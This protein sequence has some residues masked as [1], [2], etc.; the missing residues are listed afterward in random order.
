[1]AATERT[2]TSARRTTA[3]AEDKDTAATSSERGTEQTDTEQADTEQHDKDHPR[4]AT[5]NLPFVTA[6]FRAPDLHLPKPKPQEIGAALQ[7]ARSFLPPPRQALYYGGLALMAALEVVEWPVAAAIGVG[8][9][10]AGRGGGGDRGG[11]GAASK[12][13]E[14]ESSQEKNATESS[15]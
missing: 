9:A 4:T 5:V 1:M 2:R 11:G 14:T 10:L 15:E 6:Q 13:R 8:T 7:T 12:P 3:T